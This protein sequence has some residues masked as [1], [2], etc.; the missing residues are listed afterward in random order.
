M[1]T[2]PFIESAP[3]PH[4]KKSA[5]AAVSTKPIPAP[6]I[7]PLVPHECPLGSRENLYIYCTDT[8]VGQFAIDESGKIVDITDKYRGE[9]EYDNR[10]E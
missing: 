8:Q 1:D 6:P 3:L 2:W 9:M 4:P 10:P 7:Q 5:A